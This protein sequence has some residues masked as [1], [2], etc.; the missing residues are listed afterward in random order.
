MLRNVLGYVTLS[1]RCYAR[2]WFI[3]NM[4]SLYVSVLFLTHIFVSSTSAYLMLLAIWLVYP[5]FCAWLFLVFLLER[6]LVA[7]CDPTRPPVVGVSKLTLLLHRNRGVL[8]A[9]SWC[10][11]RVVL[12]MLDYVC[13]SVCVF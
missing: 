10:S 2:A 13:A 12:Q 9:V 5:L 6:T 8:R 1:C 11:F 3:C 4:Q 7:G